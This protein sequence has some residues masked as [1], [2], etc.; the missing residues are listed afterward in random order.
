MILSVLF[1]IH[2]QVD[3]WVNILDFTL[4]V[5]K[6]VGLQPPTRYSHLG[7]LSILIT[8]LC[9]EVWIILFL[10]LCAMDITWSNFV[11]IK[12]SNSPTET[13]R[14]TGA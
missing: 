13:F 4:Q 14:G 2:L 5:V 8:N 1:F 12:S 10:L 11:L 6:F 3:E 9:S 7:Q